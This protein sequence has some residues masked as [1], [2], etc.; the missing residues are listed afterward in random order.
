VRATSPSDLTRTPC[1]PPRASGG[2]AVLAVALA[3]LAGLVGG[4]AAAHDLVPGTPQERPVLLRGGDLYTVAQGVLPATDLLFAGGHITAIGKDLAAPEGAE[5]V[6]VTGQRVYPGLIAPQT[7]LGLVEIGAVR[8]TRD[9]AEVGPVTPEVAAHAAYNPD[10]E[11]LPTVRSHGVTTAQVV[12]QGR[13]LQGR[14]MIVHL[15]GWTKEDAAVRLAD[16]VEL[17]WPSAA[18]GPGFRRVP[19]AERERRR[20]EERRLL[21]RAFADARAYHLAR[22]AGVA[23][24]VD[25]RWEAMRPLFAAGQPLYVEADDVRDIREAVAFAA[26]EGVKMVLVGGKEAYRVAPLL[27]A[28]QVPVILGTTTSLPLRADDDYDL[29]YKLPRL[30]AEAGVRFCLSVDGSWEVRNLAFQA[31]QAVAFGLPEEAALRAIT[32]SAAEILG[33]AAE[34]GSLEVGK[35]ATLFV[36]RG[37]V[38][39]VLGQGVTRM[40]IEGR[41][42][43]LDDRHQQLYRKYQ[44][45]L[46]PF[47]RPAPAP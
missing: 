18:P 20:D 35:A 11:V 1:R 22:E 25:L 44:Q 29:P 23:E 15:D 47:P 5:V 26:E 41:A 36:S 45:K 33:I 6:D 39:D 43:D 19:L 2:P 24:P 38:L 21:E 17:A 13:L 27:A 28:H 10:S 9:L 8:A 16:G 34:E 12:P 14:P 42:V 32:L 3:L 30:L 46:Y 7:S 31:G 4:A 40:W 37:D